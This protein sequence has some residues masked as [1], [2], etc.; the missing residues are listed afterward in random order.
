MSET[1]S[2]PGSARPDSALPDAAPPDAQPETPGGRT[3]AAISRA[4]LDR[5]SALGY[6]G[7]SMRDIAN[8]VGIRAASLY[9]HFPSKQDIL[10][11]LTRSAHDTLERYRRDALAAAGVTDLSADPPAALRAFV[12]GHVTFHAVHRR[13]AALVNSHFAI[14]SEEQYRAVTARRRAHEA[15]LTEIIEAGIERGEF[16]VD[17]VRI[18]AYAILGMGL[19]VSVWYQ[20]SDVRPLAELSR[21]YEDIARKIVS[22]DAIPGHGQGVSHA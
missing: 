5:F 10:W 18:A 14:L 6:E 11:E 3:R 9:N 20:K 1:V 8:A 7:T 15:C 21:A 12:R 2:P 22:P 17:D 4:A 19:H 13:E 16:S